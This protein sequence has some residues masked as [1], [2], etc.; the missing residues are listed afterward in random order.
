MTIL[1][2]LS[3]HRSEYG[4]VSK[5]CPSCLS[6]AAVSAVDR[7]PR[8]VL[9]SKL[10]LEH[11]VPL[12]IIVM[13]GVGR[14]NLDKAFPRHIRDGYDATLRIGQPPAGS[15]FKKDAT[16]DPLPEQVGDSFFVLE[17]LEVVKWI[18]SDVEPA[19]NG[20][21]WFRSFRW[22][23]A[24]E[25]RHPEVDYPDNVGAEADRA[26]RFVKAIA[27]VRKTGRRGGAG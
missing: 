18:D 20:I 16:D 25:G 4:K 1:A 8:G 13:P 11:V 23:R 22:L 14:W 24:L 2:T 21:P 3:S 7:Q 9:G 15:S 5:E 26:S 27:E 17:S 10:T 12:T 6:I 19:D